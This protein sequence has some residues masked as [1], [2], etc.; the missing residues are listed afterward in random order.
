MPIVL[1]IV[2]MEIAVLISIN[3][4][5]D[6]VWIYNAVINLKQHLILEMVNM[7]ELFVEDIRR[8]QIHQ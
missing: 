6:G 5:V 2:N 8:V 1:I 4:K 3:S 7:K